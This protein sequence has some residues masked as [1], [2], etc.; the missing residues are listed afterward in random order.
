MG[1]QYLFVGAGDVQWYDNRDTNEDFRLV[2]SK[3]F[4]GTG[5][6][7]IAADGILNLNGGVIRGGVVSGTP[8]GMHQGG[9]FRDLTTTGTLRQVA[10]TETL[11]EGTITNQG[12]LTFAA[13]DNNNNTT[14]NPDTRFRIDGDV[15]LTGG[16]EVV[17]NGLATGF[18]GDGTLTNVDNTLRGNG[19]INADLINQSIVRAEGGT[20]Y[21]NPGVLVDNATGTVEIAADGILNLNGGVIRGGVVSGTPGGMHQGGTFRDLTTTGTLRQVADTETL[22]EGTITNQG[23]L[24]F[25]ADDNNNNT[26]N[27]PDT[28]FRIDGDVTLTGGGEVVF[29]GLATGFG[30]DGTLTNVDNTLRGNGSI[31]ADLINQS[32]VRAEGG[33]LYLNP[34]VLVDNATGTVEIAADGILNLNGG[35]IRGGVVSGTP[36]GMHQGG[37]FRDLTTTGTLRQVADTETLLE[38]TITNQ[39][40]LTFAADD[41]NNNTTNNP[42]TR[43][44][45]DGDVTLTGGGEVVFNGLATGFGGDG[46]LTNVDNTLRGNGSINADLIN[47]SIVRAEGGTLYL[48]PGVLVDNATGTVEIAADGILNLN[49]GV[50]RGGVVSG[51]PGGMHQGGTFRDLTTTGTLR[52]V[53]DTETLLEGTITNQG[54]LTFAADDNN[55]NTTNNPDTRFRIDGDV[56]LTGGGEVVFNGLATGFG[57]DGTLTNVDNTLRGN[58]SINA[59]LINQSI[60][61]AEGG[62]LYLNPGVLVDNATGTVEIA[63]DGILNLNGGV[64]RGGVVSGTPGGMHQGGTFRD[65]TTT[66]T[67]RQVADT[68]TLLEGTITNQG[69]LTFAADDNNNN[70]TNN[71]DT[72]FRI[73][74]DVTLTGGGEVVFNGLATGFGGDGT[75]TNVDNT[76]R[77][78]GSINADLINQSIVRAEGGTLYLNPGVLVDNATGTVEIA[79][80]GILNLNGGVIRGGVV[81]GTPGGMHQGGT[82]R[83]LTTTGTLRQVADTETL[84]EGTITNQGTLTFAADDNN[85]NTTNNPD[86]RFRIDGDVTLTGGGEVVF[87]GLATGFGGDGTLTNVD[88]TLRG[89]GSINADLINQ[90]IVRA[91]GGTL[92]LNPGVLV[93]NA[94]GTVEIAADGILN[95]NGGVIRGGVVSGTPGGMHQGGTFRDLT[96]TGT[97]RQVADTETLLEG[98]IT[99]QG[100]LTFAA[101]DNNNNTTN[102]PD[103]RFRIDGDV[104]LTGGGEVVFNGLATG[105]GG[106][107]TLTN[108]DNTLRGNG[109]INADLINR[110]NLMQRV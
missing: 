72:R 16:G 38:G 95:L 108:V 15:T 13:D 25:A 1:A 62:T 17:F 18:G 37:T 2:I 43:F 82:F 71:P 77:G 34:G 40:T 44:R 59:D 101:D 45:I 97:L 90:S 29:N 73:D 11:L 8:G 67:L 80:D 4:A 50:I 49:G 12:T 14:N 21:L 41:N 48:N 106:D 54:T 96:T 57:G 56:T 6:V 22:L 30:G 9:T 91:E 74:G 98:T 32:I 70:T 26:T 3:G 23:T 35:V 92:Y 61:R 27:N 53:A 68:E 94:T 42:D 99:N 86:T 58:G 89:N 19:S 63:A 85:N 47:Q 60:V 52:Q 39:G 107:G 87:N 109:S 36:G 10:D 104:T 33:T 81:S 5:T 51:T 88:N 69:T 31:N 64:I 105:F 66:G 78:N 100:T 102:N 75:L 65:L 76:L 110:G 83:D 24:T 93:D 79:A 20:L 55:N 28:R 84:L 7:E 46:T 103:T